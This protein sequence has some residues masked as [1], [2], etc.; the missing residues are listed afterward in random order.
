MEQVGIVQL[1]ALG[2]GPLTPSSPMAVRADF[3]MFISPGTVQ[4]ANAMKGEDS[5]VSALPQ[6][7]HTTGI[8]LV[9]GT[10]LM[11]EEPYE[12]VL[13]KWVAGLKEL[14]DARRAKMAG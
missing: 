2:K 4:M 9:E 13:V 7:R 10:L 1:L 8:Q 11:T 14:S 12:E 3:I 6:K 5:K